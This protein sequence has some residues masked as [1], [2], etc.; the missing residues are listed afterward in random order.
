MKKLRIPK[1]IL[2]VIAIF[3]GITA[4]FWVENWRHEKLKQRNLEAVLKVMVLDLDDDI[5]NLLLDSNHFIV[6][7]KWAVRLTN[8][9]EAFYNP[10]TLV[11]LLQT[12]LTFEFADISMTGYTLLLEG[13]G[14]ETTNNEKLIRDISRYYNIEVVNYTKNVE[15]EYEAMNNLIQ[16]LHSNSPY[17]SPIPKFEEITEK[18]INELIENR[19]FK[20]RINDLYDLKSIGYSLCIEM[21]ASSRNLKKSIEEEL[22][23]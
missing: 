11:D 12:Y 23:K 8:K 21:L 15:A 13:D 2:E 17:T 22:A 7:E 5:E 19:R 18:S 9:R 20:H 1:F 6:E 3:I 4:S 10:D 16:Y 14:F